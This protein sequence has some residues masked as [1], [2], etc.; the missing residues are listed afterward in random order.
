M[1]HIWGHGNGIGIEVFQESSRIHAGSI[2]N[3]APFGIGNDEYLGVFLPDIADGHLQA[4]P[5]SCSKG[6]IKGNVRFVGHRMSLSGIDNLPVEF[7]QGVLGITQEL[8][9]FLHFRIQSH[10]KIG[11]LLPDLFNDLLIGHTLAC[12][13]FGHLKTFGIFGQLQ[14]VDYGLQFSI[15]YGRQVV[16]GKINPVVGN[17]ALGVVIGTDLG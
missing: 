13:N 15:E 4:H 5:A 11:F 9:Y 14:L 16:Q 17:P 1:P 6:F 12:L 7:K 8:R 3:V 2:A 10:T